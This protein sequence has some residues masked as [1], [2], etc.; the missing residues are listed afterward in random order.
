MGFT[1]E[2]FLVYFDVSVNQEH[3]KTY[4]FLSSSVTQHA[5]LIPK[6]A[7]ATNKASSSIN[8]QVFP[9]QRLA[10]PG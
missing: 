5:Q 6:R 10:V 9:F 2:N 3:Y 1:R 4:D 8:R 7:L